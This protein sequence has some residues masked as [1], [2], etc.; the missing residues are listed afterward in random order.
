MVDAAYARR[1]ITDVLG[2]HMH[3]GAHTRINSVRNHL[4]QSNGASMTRLAA[5]RALSAGLQV[6]GTVHDAL[7]LHLP[8]ADL[9]DM[10]PALH[11]A[12]DQ[13][14]RD[15]LDYTIRHDIAVYAY[16]DRFEDPRGT[17][18]WEM[19]LGILQQNADHQSQL[20]RKNG[21]S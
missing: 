3:V 10:L 7:V 8:L 15:I 13:G 6:V 2:W 9:P 20:S 21:D 12:M 5:I 17:D 1:H 4:L 19:V 18:M 14:S 16:P 11:D